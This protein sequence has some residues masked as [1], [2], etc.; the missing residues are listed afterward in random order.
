MIDSTV[1]YGEE[2]HRQ[3][4]GRAA[5]AR[6]RRFVIPYAASDAEVR[7][8]RQRRDPRDLR[9]A[10]VELQTVLSDRLYGLLFPQERAGRVVEE[11]GAAKGVGAIPRAP[12]CVRTPR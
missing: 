8:R 6:P 9:L 11:L 1:D 5:A 12:R 3:R 2:S 7:P 4:A 10:P